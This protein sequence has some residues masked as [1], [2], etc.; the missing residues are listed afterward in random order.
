MGGK[1][2]IRLYP[3]PSQP[4]PSTLQSSPFF[5]GAFLL[6]PRQWLLC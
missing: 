3:L 5:K 4:L 2:A 1:R 6:Q